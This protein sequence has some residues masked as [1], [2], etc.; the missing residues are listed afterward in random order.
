MNNIT[1]PIENKI[2]KTLEPMF[3]KW[4][5]DQGVNHVDYGDSFVEWHDRGYNFELRLKQKK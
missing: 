5:K 3:L 2:F 4:L 1:E